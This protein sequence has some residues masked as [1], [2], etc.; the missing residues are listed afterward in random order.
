MAASN[1]QGITEEVFSHDG[2]SLP[3]LV[4]G[5]GPALIV[6]HELRGVTPAF[7]DFSARIAAA[8]FTVATPLFFGTPGNNPRL[9]GTLLN[10]ARICVSK[11][12]AALQIGQSGPISDWLRALARTLHQRCGGPGVGVLGMCFTGNFALAALVEPSV[13]AAVLAQPALPM[14]KAPAK[15]PDLHLSAAD[16]AAVKQRVAAERIPVLALRFSHD[17][18]CPGERFQRLREE[19]GDQAECIEIDSGPDNPHG[20]RPKAHSVLTRELVDAAGHPTREAYD[21]VLAYFSARL[22]A[23]V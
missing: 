7:L 18:L 1:L 14:G 3:V 22:L 20:I 21:R 17:A 23:T 13:Q 11:E 12:F 19:L 16:L 9:V 5:Q 2:K 6:M 4:R 10:V 8:G 15:A